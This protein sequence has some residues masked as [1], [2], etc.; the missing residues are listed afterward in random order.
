MECRIRSMLNLAAAARRAAHT[1]PYM[2]DLPLAPDRIA[3]PA[4][5]Y[6]S[7]ARKALVLIAVFSLFR[8]LLAFGLELG[9]DEA[10]YWMYSQELKLNYFDHPPMVAF[11]IR[12]FTFNGLLQGAGWLRLGAVVS[13]A[14]AAWLLFRAVTAIH[15]PRAGLYAS[16]LYLSSFYAGLTAG[17][18]IMPDSPQMVFWT[19]ALW[20]LVRI[21]ANERDWRSWLLFGLCAGLAILSKVHAGFLW[22]GLGAHIL[23]QRRHWLRLP[24]LYAAAAVTALLLTPILAWNIQNDFITYRFHSR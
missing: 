12:L 15:S 21:D 22:I 20:M 19:A 14:V 5:R 11:L 6:R 9:N 17:V 16:V 23:F 8:L 2:T 24:Q 10:Y 3:V 4:D 18:Y 1:R 7:Y 13:A